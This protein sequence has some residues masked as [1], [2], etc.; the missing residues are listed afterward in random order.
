MTATQLC[1]WWNWNNPLFD[2]Y[3]CNIFCRYFFNLFCKYFSTF[4][5]R[6]GFVN[7]HR[8]EDAS[9]AIQ[10]LNGL[11]LQNKTIKVNKWNRTRSK[12]GTKDDITLICFA[13]LKP[14]PC[15]VSKTIILKQICKQK[16][17]T[18][19]ILWHKHLLLHLVFIQFL[20]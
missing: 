3:F 14:R 15:K 12:N 8:I 4:F 17:E 5:C 9:K 10:T 1:F 19:M 6:Y 18:F 2:R 16:H 13:L 11:R 20:I 7:Y